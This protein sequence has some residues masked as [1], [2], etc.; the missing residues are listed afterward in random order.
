MAKDP[1]AEMTAVADFI[2]ALRFAA[3]DENDEKSHTDLDVK[4]CL[5]VSVGR[6]TRG[7]GGGPVGE[8]TPRGGRR[9]AEINP[10]EVTDALELAMADEEGVVGGE[11]HAAEATPEVGG[12]TD[13]PSQMN[14]EKRR[15]SKTSS[16]DDDDDDDDDEEEEE[17]YEDSDSSIETFFPRSESTDD[18]IAIIREQENEDDLSESSQAS[19][20]VVASAEVKGWAGVRRRMAFREPRKT[21]SIFNLRNRCVVWEQVMNPIWSRKQ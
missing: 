6:G 2:H 12:Q 20:S 11:S 9:A 3:L 5:K 14:L 19:S 15:G 21:V 18:I 16:F 13:R 1:R 17:E 8:E 10:G 7:E 4:S